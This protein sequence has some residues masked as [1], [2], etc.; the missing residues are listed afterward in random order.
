LADDW[1]FIMD[2]AADRGLEIA[3]AA[4]YLTLGNFEAFAQPE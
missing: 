1:S 2:T 4:R 3:A